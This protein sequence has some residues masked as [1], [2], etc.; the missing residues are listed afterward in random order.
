MSD[1]GF[2]GFTVAAVLYLILFRFALTLG[3]GHYLPPVFAGWITNVVFLTYAVFR[4][5]KI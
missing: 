2:L 1:F 5:V 3:K 4:I